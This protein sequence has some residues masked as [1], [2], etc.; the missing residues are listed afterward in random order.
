MS[1]G[2]LPP[3][4]VAHPSGRG[5]PQAGSGMLGIVALLGLLFALVQGTLFYRAK[6]SAKFLASEKNKILAQQI[7]EAGVEENIADLGSRKI[8]PVTGM[9]HHTTYTEKALGAGTFSTQLTTLVVSPEADTLE[10][11]SLGRVAAVQQ[12]VRARLR[13]KR[14]LDTTLTP[15]MEVNP[16]TTITRFT[17]TRPETT[18]TVTV[19]DPFAMP[20]LDATPA[21]DACMA[22][23]SKKCEVCHIPGGNPDNRHVIDISKSA[24]HTHISHHGDYVTTDGTCDIYN[25]R[26]TEVIGI[27]TFPDSTVTITDH[28]VYDTLSVIDTLAKVQILSWK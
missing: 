9:S 15:I 5:G 3:V 26:T 20:A 24:I 28:T 13:V 2:P 7:A 12:S 16:E 25:P 27:G 4:E 21:Y 23:S 8:I 6:S 1:P 11:T 14:Y 17:T 22:S 19:Q 18:T 10:L